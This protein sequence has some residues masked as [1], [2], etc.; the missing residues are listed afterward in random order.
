MIL[1]LLENAALY[2]GI[3]DS[4][5]VGID[6]LRINDY[7]NTAPGSYPIEGTGHVVIVQEFIT[8]PHEETKWETHRSNIDIQY[9]ISGAERVGFTP[10]GALQEKVP[11]NPELD[12]TY[13]EGHGNYFEFKE[14]MCAV[15]FPTDAHRCCGILD[16][17][18][19]V[20]KVCVKIRI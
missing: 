18:A 13:Y 15:F 14:G 6:H 17:P 9:V 1:D 4:I 10:S 3:D 7:R 19:S 12:R 2:E 8:R 16:M 20:K 11:Y 5:A